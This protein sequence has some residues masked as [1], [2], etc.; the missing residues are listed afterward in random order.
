[1]ATTCAGEIDADVA[2]S[3]G[4][5]QLGQDLADDFPRGAAKLSRRAMTHPLAPTPAPRGR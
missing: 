2:D 3:A 5:A 4:A 1:M